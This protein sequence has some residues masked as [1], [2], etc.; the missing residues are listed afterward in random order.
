MGDHDEHD[1]IPKSDSNLLEM[2]SLYK[3]YPRNIFLDTLKPPSAKSKLSKIKEYEVIIDNYEDEARNSS[4]RVTAARLPYWVRA[5]WIYLYDFVGQKRMHDVKWTDDSTDLQKIFIEVHSKSTTASNAG[6]LYKLTVFIKTGSFTVQGTNRS[7]FKNNHFKP[8]CTIVDMLE[9]K[10]G[11]QIHVDQT[12]LKIP[13]LPHTPKL[14]TDTKGGSRIPIL[15]NGASPT[16]TNAIV[17]EVRDS[18]Q[19][20]ERTFSDSIAKICEAQQ[21]SVVAELQRLNEYLTGNEGQIQKNDPK[22]DT[23]IQSLR[24]EILTLK[25]KIQTQQ[26]DI[27]AQKNQQK[28]D[29]DMYAHNLKQLTSDNELER[30]ILISKHNC[31][32]NELKQ[33]LESENQIR[34][35]LELVIDDQNSKIYSLESKINNL[36]ECVKELKDEKDTLSSEIIS[37]K[38]HNSRQSNLN[39][40]DDPSVGQMVNTKP[41]EVLLIGTSNMAKVDPDKLSTKFRT[42]KHIAYNFEQTKDCIEKEESAYNLICLHS[43]TNEIKDKDADL[44]VTELDNIIQNCATKWPSAKVVVSLG[45][46]RKD[47]F[48]NKLNLANALVR[49]KYNE[50]DKVILCDHSNL[51]YRGDP[52]TK[53]MKNGDDVHLND[54]GVKQFAANIKSSILSCLGLPIFKSRNPNQGQ[55]GRGYRGNGGNRNRQFGNKRPPRFNYNK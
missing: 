6:M 36:A 54:S 43:L 28:V 52:Q 39:P 31:E 3:T 7:T 45:T 32:V 22:T 13:D 12:E 23:K 16:V 11:P 25:T 26:C 29:K 30:Q 15:R 41:P 34:K 2:E 48:N 24:E 20:M 35:R 1:G 4:F 40:N 55:G 50:S 42:T 21:S 37:L 10:F 17:Q 19:H 9:T 49:E 51:S 18:F 46:P 53:F 14:A 33:K 44:C 5:L 38:L 8:L 27:Q 47:K